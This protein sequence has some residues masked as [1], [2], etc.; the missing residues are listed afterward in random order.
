MRAVGWGVLTPDFL[1]ANMDRIGAYALL[2]LG[3]WA[4]VTGRLITVGRLKDWQDLVSLLREENKQLRD[5]LA[6]LNAP[7]ESMVEGQRET[8]RILDAL[9]ERT[10]RQ[11]GRAT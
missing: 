11:R 8:N 9:A 6:G 10:T 7:L 1:L 3:V 5:A 4:L 2:L